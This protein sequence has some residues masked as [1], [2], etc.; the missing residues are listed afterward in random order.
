MTLFTTSWDD[1]HPLDRKLAD[2]MAR[3]GIAG[4]FYCPL[5]NLEGPAVMGAADLRALDDA[6]RFEVGSH[7]LDHVY[8]GRVAASEWAGQVR[9]GKAALEDLLGHAVAGFCYPGGQ[10]GGAAAAVVAAA[11][12][13]YAR[14]TE[15]LRADCGGDP[16]AVPTTLQFYPHSRGV[17]A[18]NWVARGAWARRG[19]IALAALSSAHLERR[20]AAALGRCRGGVMHLWGHSWEVERLGLWPQL[21]RF[22]AAVAAVVPPDARL[23]N[24]AL[25]QRVGL[26]A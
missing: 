6:G 24:A 16:F 26:L 14:T 20:L 21:D 25:L 5:H 7:T 11:G 1:G 12:F 23:T 13:R 18:R 22:F 19:G 2:L 3:H 4:T 9:A 15:N 10:R 17:I 8:A